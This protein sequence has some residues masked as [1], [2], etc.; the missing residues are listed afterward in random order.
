MWLN[1]LVC[2]VMS[3]FLLLSV[4]FFTLFE[5]K[6]LGFIQLRKGPN[7]V[8]FKGVFQPFSDAV[9]LFTK[10]FNY[11]WKSNFYPYWV[12]PFLA[13]IISL[14]FW[15]CFP[16]IYLITSWD[17]GILFLFSMMS[18]SVY[19]VM[20]SGWFSNS[21]YSVLGSI[22]CIAQSISYE[23]SFFLMVLCLIY[24]TC[25]MNLHD[26]LNFQKENVLL[27]LHFP[28]FIMFLVSFLAELNR[29]PFDF[30]EGESELVSGFNVEYGGVGFSFIFLAEYLMI[31]F[32]SMLICF[33]FLGVSS[34]KLYFYMLFC[35]M[36]GFFILIRASLPRYRYDK[37]MDMCWKGYLTCTL[38][39]I[40]FYGSISFV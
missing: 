39:F 15:L 17:Y 30:S 21:C 6:I 37:L 12:S 11:P 8:G 23:V 9:K 10:E 18:F 14:F 33:L 29:T 40:L 31:L 4:A 36:G 2:M 25:S 3:F 32:A 16:Y 19:S 24:F 5:R 22:R 38:N 26:F 7:K 34:S 13:L 20:I 35:L 27:F 28:V 1:L